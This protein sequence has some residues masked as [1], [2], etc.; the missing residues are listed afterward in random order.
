VVPGGEGTVKG[1]GLRFAQVEVHEKRHFRVTTA[2]ALRKAPE[3]RDL[4][5]RTKLLRAVG[6]SLEPLHAERPTR[7]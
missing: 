7:L 1:T 3:M 2:L 5:R 4:Q 6:A